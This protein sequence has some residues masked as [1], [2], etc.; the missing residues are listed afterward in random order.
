MMNR[1]EALF[2]FGVAAI[3]AATPPSS[4]FVR[5]IESGLPITQSDATDA[6]IDDRLRKEI[7]EQAARSTSEEGVAVL[8]ACVNL[9]EDKSSGKVPPVAPTKLSTTIAAELRRDSAAWER[10]QPNAPA[11]DIAKLIQMLAERDFAGGGTEK[12]S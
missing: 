8:L 12:E 11:S 6:N 3:G 7:A 4:A 10:I 2:G 5:I 9:V 1:R